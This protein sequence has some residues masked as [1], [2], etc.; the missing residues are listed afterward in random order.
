MKNSLE[1]LQIA[2]N[3]FDAVASKNLDA[4][5]SLC[6]SNIT[7]DS[8]LGK[9]QGI[10]GFKDFTE[11]FFRMIEKLTPVS[12]LGWEGKATIVYVAD[13]LPVKNSYVAEYLVIQNGKILSNV[14][15]YN[16]IPYMEYAS[17]Q[18]RH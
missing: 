14:T 9:L 15:I 5:L 13:T 12:V 18:Q 16:G 3:Y 1:T 4:V 6:D 2:Q 17:K 8:P 7:V 11:G 10:N